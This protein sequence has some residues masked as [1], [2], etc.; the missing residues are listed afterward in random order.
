MT[1]IEAGEPLS[2]IGA[3]ARAALTRRLAEAGV[4][5]ATGSPAV[6]ISATGVTLADGRAIP[7]AFTIGAAAQTSDVAITTAR[8]RRLV[9]AQSVLSFGFNTA[10]LALAI[11]LAA[12]VF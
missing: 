7:S 3:A 9:M 4:T 8:M 5:L 6:A 12:S 1:L 10:V 2:T 11:N